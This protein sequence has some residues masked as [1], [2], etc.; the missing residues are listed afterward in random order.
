MKAKMDIHQEKMATIH[1]IW[2]ELEETIK[3]QMKEVLSCVDKKTLGLCKEL[4]EKIDKTQVDLQAI[5]TVI[6][7]WTKSLLD[8]ITDTREHLHEE[9]GLIIQGEAQMMKTL[10]DTTWRGLKAKIPEVE[11]QVECGRGTGTG[12][13][14]V[15]P[16]TFD[17]TSWA[18]YWHQFK[19]IALHNCWTRLE[20]STYFFTAFQGWATEV[21]SESR[22]KQPVKKPLRPW[23]NASGTSTW[24]LRVAFS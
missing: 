20:K 21:R 24:L 4:T 1:S 8:T 9:L 7:T 14:T 18:A 19:T 10:I 12:A 16:P 2:S 6:D 3:Y 11:A 17:R 5:R 23:R 22:K 13:G 15:K